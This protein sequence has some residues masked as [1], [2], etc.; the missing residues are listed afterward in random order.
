MTPRSPATHDPT[1]PWTLHPSPAP[2]ALESLPFTCDCPPHHETA[3]CPRG[4]RPNKPPSRLY[5]FQQ[6]QRA[7]STVAGAGEDGTAALTPVAARRHRRPVVLLHRSRH[8]CHRPVDARPA[9][10]AEQG[11]HAPATDGP[12]GR[13]RAADIRCLSA[14]L[15]ARQRDANHKKCKPASLSDH[16]CCC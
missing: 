4:L 1:Q 15:A 9:R 6:A 8:Q 11:R 5:R 12:F 16:V 7:T 14:R 3:S 13:S 2:L 10:M